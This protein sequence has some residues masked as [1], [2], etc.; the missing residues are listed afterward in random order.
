VQL[1][2][3]VGLAQATFKQWGEHKSARLAAALAYYTI[4]SIAPLLLIAIAVAGLVF[5]HDAASR[6]ILGQ[7]GGFIGQKGEH[8][9]NTMVSAANKPASG[10]VA[11]ESLK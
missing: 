3:T 4:F 11:I 7:I 9:L 6:E 10:I 8:Q 2:D 5:G 1:H